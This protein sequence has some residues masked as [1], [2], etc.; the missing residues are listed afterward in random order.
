[1]R[2]WAEKTAQLVRRI[3]LKKA[4]QGK[5][6][7]IGISLLFYDPFAKDEEKWN[8]VIE[9]AGDPNEGMPEEDR[10]IMIAAFEY[11]MEG[12]KR[13]YEKGVPSEAEMEPYTA[14]AN[15]H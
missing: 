7:P 6:V 12:V 2:K 11:I 14:R 10:E 13:I 9:L 4:A 8:Y 5:G 15:F 1:M 3:C